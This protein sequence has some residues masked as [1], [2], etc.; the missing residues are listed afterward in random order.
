MTYVPA[1]LRRLV[2]ERASGACEYC[3][4][5]EAMALVSHEVDHVVA[6]K[7]GGATDA[8]NLALSCTLCNKHKGSDL[9]SIDPETGDLTPLFHPR[10]QRWSEQFQ[11]VDVMIV[12]R[13]PAG[14]ATVR[15]LQ[16]NHPDRLTVRALLIAAELIQPPA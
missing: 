3:L 13:T 5:P 4:A 14:R 2:R 16:L 9:A 11:L 15:L 8:D 7:H 10:L 6:Q 1:A 12:P